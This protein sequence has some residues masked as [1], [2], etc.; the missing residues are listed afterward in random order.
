MLR[1]VGLGVQLERQGNHV[2]STH[3][4][5]RQDHVNPGETTT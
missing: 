1:G 4:A 5:A 3:D 2:L